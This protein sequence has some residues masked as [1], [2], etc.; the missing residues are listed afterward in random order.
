M[1]YEPLILIPGLGATRNLFRQQLVAL[2]ARANC[3]VVRHG[4]FADLRMEAGAIL[5][6][7]PPKFGLAGHSMGG[8]LALEIMRRAP[9][10]VTRLALIDTRASADT[11][12][13]RTRREELIKLAEEEGLD[14]V[15]KLLW[16]RLVH[17]SKVRD[18]GL[19]GL[20][21]GMLEETGVDGFIRQQR[22]ILS[23]INYWG[24]LGAIQVPT[25]IIVGEQ[26]VV[27]PPSAA[28]AM[29]GAIAGADLTIVPRCGH[30]APLE[31]VFAVNGA[32]ERW[33]ARKPTRKKAPPPPWKMFE[34]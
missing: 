2:S 30:L 13:E 32:L 34:P 4:R 6:E 31:Q 15:H 16:P 9:E 1:A 33:L 24:A 12:D 27:T 23:R 3:I 29:Q 20:V 19:E 11:D 10:R 7:A 21:R 5:S 28:K 22:A 8:Y 25:T 14:S 17:S 18:A 26:D